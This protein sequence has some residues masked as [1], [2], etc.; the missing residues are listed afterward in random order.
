[1]TLAGN[2]KL[3]T[4]VGIAAVAVFGAGV[5]STAAVFYLMPEQSETP[6]LSPA[7]QPGPVAPPDKPPAPAPATPAG[8]LTPAQTA[9]MGYA[10]KDIGGKKRKDV[11]KGKPYK[12]NVYQDDGNSTA[13]RA[14]LDLDRDDKWDEKYTF[15][16]DS[17]QRQVSPDDDENYTQKFLWNG[18]DWAPE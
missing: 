16:G 12:I 14:K 17:V 5:L 7:P 15:G 11:S 2:M 13:N 1:M 18:E 10:G 4:F 9:I 3:K 6:T 8:N